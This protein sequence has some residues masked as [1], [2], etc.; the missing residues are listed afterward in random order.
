LMCLPSLPTENG[1]QCAFDHLIPLMLSW[2]GPCSWSSNPSPACEW[3]RA[4]KMGAQGFWTNVEPDDRSSITS[5]P[6]VSHCC[7][8]TIFI[9]FARLPRSRLSL[10]GGSTPDELTCSD[11]RC[12][13]HSPY[14]ICS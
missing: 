2:F 9:V 6:K 13:R 1:A 8:K 7:S 12:D 4:F 14:H 3:I 10:S 5:T 11:S